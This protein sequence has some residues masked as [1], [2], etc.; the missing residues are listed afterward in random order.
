[1]K[2][3]ILIVDDEA[4]MHRIFEINLSPKRYRFQN[5]SD[6][7]LTARTYAPLVVAS[8]YDLIANYASFFPMVNPTT[9]P[10]ITDMTV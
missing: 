10:T 9:A 8:R 4:R 6:I 7:Q 3:R 2:P 5:R 1:M